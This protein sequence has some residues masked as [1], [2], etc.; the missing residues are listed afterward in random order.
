VKRMVDIDKTAADYMAT[1]K[2]IIENQ[3][4]TVNSK[5]LLLYKL[6]GVADGFGR[7]MMSHATDY[8]PGVGPACFSAAN[9]IQEMA[10]SLLGYSKPTT[11]HHV[12][13]QETENT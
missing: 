1:A 10:E 8:Q 9:T 11:E 6:S 12:Q 13:S 7:A 2:E 3:M 4:L 5:A